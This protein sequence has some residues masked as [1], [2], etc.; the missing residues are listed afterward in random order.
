LCGYTT[1]GIEPFT[2]RT[3]L[4][5]STS[6]AALGSARSQRGVMRFSSSAATQLTRLP[7]L[8]RGSPS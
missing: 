1:S 6:P 2:S 7:A 4:K 3:M 8:A 5:S